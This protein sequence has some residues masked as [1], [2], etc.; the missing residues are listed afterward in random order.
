MGFEEDEVKILAIAIL[1]FT[2][3]VSMM[4]YQYGKAVAYDEMIEWLRNMKRQ[5]QGEQIASQPPTLHRRL[6]VQDHVSA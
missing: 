6:P 2:L 4:A 5:K 3:G 1:L